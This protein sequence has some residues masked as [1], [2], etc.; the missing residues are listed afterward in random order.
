MPAISLVRK[1]KL[2]ELRS[3]YAAACALAECQYLSDES[4]H[5]ANS[6]KKLL[7]EEIAE[8]KTPESTTGD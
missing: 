3:G 7:A 4:L 8:L 2:A 6:L 5:K 1:D